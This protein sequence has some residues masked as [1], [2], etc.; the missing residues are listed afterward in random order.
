MADKG[1]KDVRSEGS[2]D[3]KPCFQTSDIKVLMNLHKAALQHAADK[4]R[5]FFQIENMQDVLVNTMLSEDGKSI[6]NKEGQ[7]EVGFVIQYLDFHR[8]T[9][10]ETKKNENDFQKAFQETN[11]EGLKKFQSNAFEVLKEYLKR[12][13][14][15]EPD[16]S[17]MVDFIPDYNGERVNVKKGKIVSMEENKRLDYLANHSDKD[18][19]RLGFKFGFTYT[20]KAAESSDNSG[21]EWIANAQNNG[22]K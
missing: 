20:S 2:I 14:D 17:K 21:G 9:D 22:G 18:K 19:P 7:Y 3:E 4:A 12:F 16:A 1:T 15:A 10:E 8:P 6:S 13:A 11:K 5:G